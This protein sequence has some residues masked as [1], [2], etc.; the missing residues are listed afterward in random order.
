MNPSGF[1]VDPKELLNNGCTNLK[2]NIS[3][4]IIKKRE[5]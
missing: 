2:T 4:N 1:Y 3:A 5:E